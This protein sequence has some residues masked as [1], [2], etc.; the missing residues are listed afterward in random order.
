MTELIHFDEK[1]FHLINQGLQNPFFDVVMP[2]LRNKLF[3]VPLYLFIGSFLIVNLRKTGLIIVLLT[4]LTVGLTD[5]SNSQVLK[6]SI[7][8]ARPCH[9]YQAPAELNLLVPCGGGYSFP[10]SHAAN[11]FALATILT[12]LLRPLFRWL[13]WPLGAWAFL[14]AFAQIY[15]GVHYPLDV[16]FGA[17]YGVFVA[18]LMGSLGRCW[19]Q[20]CFGEQGQAL[21][22]KQ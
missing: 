6:K 19:V 16:L 3:W 20:K 15:V 17:V 2:W 18:F 7:K 5:F 1:L 12:L 22:N 21:N 13:V 11:H 10:S 9:I 8:R 4:G 14:V